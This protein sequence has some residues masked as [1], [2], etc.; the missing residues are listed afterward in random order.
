MRSF[1]GYAQQSVAI[2]LKISSFVLANTQKGL[3]IFATSQ[4]CLASVGLYPDVEPLSLDVSLRWQD[5]LWQQR[6][7]A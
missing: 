7:G 4:L 1:R 5:K 6:G 3:Q 2:N